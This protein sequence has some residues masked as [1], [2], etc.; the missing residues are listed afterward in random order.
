MISIVTASAQS[1]TQG[2][3]LG[4]VTDPS[5]AVVPGATVTLKNDNTGATQTR[6]TNNSGFYEFALLPPGSYMLSVTAQSYQAAS[7]R[8]SASIGQVTTNNVRLAVA[9]SS[10][11]VEV[12]AEG[13]VV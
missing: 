11:T 7:Q 9:S 4:T 2:N 5:G 12:T 10:Q 6:T 8:V 1:L 13:S 3:I